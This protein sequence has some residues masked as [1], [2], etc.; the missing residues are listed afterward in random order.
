MLRGHDEQEMR[1]HGFA[2]DPHDTNKAVLVTDLA[3]CEHGAT[4]TDGL[5][6]DAAPSRLDVQAEPDPKNESA[7][8]TP[9]K[10]EAAVRAT[11]GQTKAV[12]KTNR[13]AKKAA[14]AGGT[15]HG[16]N[17]SGGSPAPNGGGSK[18]QLFPDPSP[19][20][21][22]VLLTSIRQHGV[23]NAII[24]DEQGNT[25]EGHRRE[26]IATTLCIPCP[27]IVHTFTTEQEKYQFALE[28]N[29]ARRH[30][31]TQ[32]QKRQVIAAYL[33]RDPE[34]SNNWMAEILGVSDTTVKEVRKELE[35]T[36]QIGKLAKLRGK[37]GKKRSAKKKPARSKPTAGKAA[38][39]KDTTTADPANG[40][41]PTD[42]SAA[43]SPT[44][45]ATAEAEPKRP[46]VTT[47]GPSDDSNGNATVEDGDVHEDVTEDEFDDESA[48]AKPEVTAEEALLPVT[49]DQIGAADTFVGA[50]GG[51]QHAVRV[52]IVKSANS[53]D[54]DAVKGA[55]AEAVR[56]ARAVLTPS[57][58]TAVVIVGAAK[59]QGIK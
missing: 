31:L 57:E 15:P 35:A 59:E 51:V 36:S 48:D 42:E 13:V 12:K 16:N 22:Q 56:A 17:E 50:V 30:H 45:G 34:I 2:I 8:D 26:R 54:K 55:L 28:A 27:S 44:P 4:S 1:K 5:G 11:A 20:E 6:D 46:T 21:D 40:K 25:I 38:N 29:Q 49:A 32:D 33:Q 18:Y 58:I 10:S 43:I 47:A 41:Q 24:K 14:Q 52:L 53:G 37:D 3:D 9:N 23:L 39:Q 19:E 7:P